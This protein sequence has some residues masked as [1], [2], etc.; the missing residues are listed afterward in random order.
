VSGLAWDAAAIALY[1]IAAALQLHALL[2]GG[3]RN[4]AI[5]PP[6][7]NDPQIFMWGLAWYPHALTH[8]LDPL[9]TNNVFAP[10]GYNL[11]WS[12]T[13]PA[14]ALLM[15]PITT[16]FG[17]LVSFNLLCI[18]TPILSAYTAFA[19]CRHI[20]RR[21]LPSLVGGL[22]YGFSTYQIVEADH[23]NLALT[24]IPQLLALLFVSRCASEI[25]RVRYVSLFAACLIFQFLISPE[26]FETATLFGVI[27]IA[28]SAWM[29]DH[30]WRIRL[31]SVLGES[32]VAILTAVVVLSPYIYRFVPSPFG[33]SPIYNPAH[34]ST[35]LLGFV[36]PTWNSLAGRIA[37]AP[38]YDSIIGYGCEPAAYMGLLPGIAVWLALA[39]RAKPANAFPVERF[40]ALTLFVIML[41][42]L[43]PII[44]VNG[45]D[46][47][48]S[49]WLPALV[50]P[51]V[52]NA[53]PARFVLYAFLTLSV[54]VTLWLCDSRRQA[55]TRWVAAIFALIS[56]L[57]GPVPE[58]PATLPFFTQQSYREYLS[59][60]ETIA[61]L[62]F[63]PYGEAM[64]WQAQ[65]NFYFRV[66]GGYFS[67][68]PH[69]YAAWPIVPALMAQDPYI[70]GYGDQ[71]K[72]FLAAHDVRTVIVTEAAYPQY[73]KLCS[74]L[75]V[76]PVHIGGVVLFGLTPASLASAARATAD[77]MD[78]RFNYDRYTIL[79]RAARE[80]IARGNSPRDLSPFAAERLGLIDPTVVGYPLLRQ[81]SGFP[82]L[83]AATDAYGFHRIADYLISHQMIRERL[84]IELGPVKPKDAT[85]SGIWL[86]P[87]NDDSIAVGVVT[88]RAAAANLIARFGANADSIYYPYPLRYSEGPSI[89]GDPQMLLM[90]FKIAA[91][92]KLEEPARSHN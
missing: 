29:G 50:V 83:H 74:T 48:P 2:S 42:A 92:S 18:L 20:S 54:I 31:R 16:R 28:I 27:A 1:A 75:E 51:I 60:N 10:S 69:E 17:P 49:V 61:V 67:F 70:P 8:G 35:D 73:A 71:F 90:T 79:I 33:L 76:P 26:V 24:F 52:N 81:T 30:Q 84:A 78:T 40:L 9:F 21:P 23:L 43:G 57:P 39:S 38:W 12:T 34:C 13:L 80:F 59:P 87:W 22:V 3:I 45:I 44:H 53:L 37:S 56:V 6:W 86:G 32:I 91:L 63:G 89:P 19:L 65:S 14:P 66:A 72:A 58:V 36:I 25:G 77:A 46:R 41:I 11:A 7:S 4:F 82:M 88:G 5:G 64:K 62:P 15:W 55:T 68:I 47:A 85:K